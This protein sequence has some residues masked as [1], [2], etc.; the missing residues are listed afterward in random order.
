MATEIEIFV[1]EVSDV[2]AHVFARYNGPP[3]LDAGDK[4]DTR[5]FLTGTLRGP[6]CEA[7]RTLP[8]EFAFR[9]AGSGEAP[10]AEAVVP[11]PCQWSPELPHVYHVDVEARRKGRVLARHR[12]TIGLRRKRPRRPYDFSTDGP[13]DE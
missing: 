9:E 7:A 10:L 4:T 8:A 11:D 5:I 1:G 3:A 6:F 13:N 2:E 12:A